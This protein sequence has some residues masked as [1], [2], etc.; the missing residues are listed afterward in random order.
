MKIGIIGAGVAGLASAIRM[1]ARGHEVEVFES[2]SF[3]GGKLSEFRLDGYRFDAGP[4][5]FTQAHYVDELFEL[6]GLNPTD[7]FNYERL[8]TVCHYFWEDQTRIKA[9]AD[10]SK[11]AA[12]VA[13]Q[14]GVDGNQILRA[15]SISEKKYKVTGK[16]FLENS[17]HKAGTWLNTK[18]LR[19]M[20]QI[21][22]LDL[23]R[24][25]HKT[26]SAIFDHPKLVQLFNRFATYN[27]SNPYKTPGLMNIIPYFEHKVGA[28]FPKG[29]MNAIAQSLYQLAI[30]RGVK[31][32]FNSLVDKIN[33]ENARVQSIVS[34]NRIL[35]FDQI[36]C[37]MDIFFAYKR[38]LPD[39]KQ[40]TRIL[41]QPKSTSALIFYWGI[42]KEFK[43]LG[44]HNILFSENYEEEFDCMEKGDIT[45]DPT[46]YIHVSSKYESGDAPAG[47]ENW[48]TMIN[49][50]FNSGQDWDDLIVK[51]RA[52]IIGKIKRTLGVN[53]EPLIEVEEVLDPR[54][55]ESR[56][57]SHLGS[58]YGTSS[59]NRMAAFLRHPNFSG[60]IKGLYFCGGSV[61]PGGGIPLC[62][63]SAKIIDGLM[64]QKT[65]AIE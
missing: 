22:G 19:A 16:I 30:R 39:Q 36:I 9:W 41:R 2:N 61:H 56:T 62:L 48:F 50:P 8:E 58:L 55:I 65:T 43:E 28:Y 11:F 34:Q 37:N 4:S 59:N 17:L 63:L 47:C 20:L 7:H 60:K 32:H 3:P 45:H 27:G 5:L 24:S 44:L 42:K 1:A 15:L 31:F 12:E 38:L 10:P 52:N 54:S 18:V 51:S 53:V 49:V 29:G 57:Q 14:L 26:N 46:V 21:P 13:Q 40:P 23:F 35:N 6:C 33:I 64:H 25:M